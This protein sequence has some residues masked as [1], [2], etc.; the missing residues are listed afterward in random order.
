MNDQCCPVKAF[1]LITEDGMA[2]GPV[3][4]LHTSLHISGAG[5]CSC[6][7]QKGLWLCHLK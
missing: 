4:L 7:L 1:R 2:V 3:P 6:L 5:G